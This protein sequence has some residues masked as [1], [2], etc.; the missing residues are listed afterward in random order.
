MS[1]P[2]ELG[3]FGLPPFRQPRHRHRAPP[4]PFSGIEAAT[5]EHVKAQIEFE[6]LRE[7]YREAKQKFKE[8][9]QR[10]EDAE[11]KLDMA[12]RYDKAQDGAYAVC[13]QVKDRFIR[14]ELLQ[15]WNALTTDMELGLAERKAKYLELEEKATNM[16][17][18]EGTGAGA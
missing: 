9:R 2:G 4:R 6:E 18:E 8:A 7:K 12:K 3:M 14:Q 15:E 13:R 10:V 16:L 11:R 17:Q 1:W 5:R